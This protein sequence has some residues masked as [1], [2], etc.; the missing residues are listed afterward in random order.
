MTTYAKPSFGPQ[1]VIPEH[2]T[3][4]SARAINDRG[5]PSFLADR[6]DSGGPG[7]S[8]LLRY[9]NGGKLQEI[10]KQIQAW[11]QAASD[12]ESTQ[13]VL[14]HWIRCFCRARGGYFYI[15]VW[16]ESTY[17]EATWSGKGRGY[18]T[19]PQPGEP[20]VVAMNKIGPAIVLGGFVEA[21]YQGVIAL[22]TDPPP[23]FVKQNGAGAL[24]GVFGMELE[25][26]LPPPPVDWT[27]FGS[28]RGN[29]VYVILVA[30]D[31]KRVLLGRN[32]ASLAVVDVDQADRLLHHPD[33]AISQTWED[34]SLERE[35][36]GY[37]PHTTY[38]AIWILS[39]QHPDWK[40]YEKNIQESLT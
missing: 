12:G 21:T 3:W 10:R 11:F 9:L 24:C 18:V 1:G 33:T 17:T 38:H 27:A 8:A 30:P 39:R 32:Y 35:I 13:F 34:Y 6:Q 2:A 31:G 23:W 28:G 37:A 19:A 20:V 25:S 5:M 36:E 40:N 22:P 29:E 14:D 7:V 15:G 16:V 26:I 4:W